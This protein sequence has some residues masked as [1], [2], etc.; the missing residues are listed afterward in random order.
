M[1]KSLF[2]RSFTFLEIGISIFIGFMLGLAILRGLNSFYDWSAI[3]DDEERDF[4]QRVIAPLANEG[5]ID[6]WEAEEW[7][8]ERRTKSGRYWISTLLMILQLAVAIT[9][10]VM[11]I[12]QVYK[13]YRSLQF[14]ERLK[15]F[16]L[17]GNSEIM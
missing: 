10:P 5:K 6:K 13:K 7:L 1:I 4:K 14:R 9:V 16:L 12:G 8:E 2:L 17:K 11:W 3:Y 15:K